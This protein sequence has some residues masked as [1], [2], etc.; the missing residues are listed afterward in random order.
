VLAHQIFDRADL[1][2]LLLAMRCALFHSEGRAASGEQQTDA[3]RKNEPALCDKRV[4]HTLLH[5]P[6]RQHAVIHRNFQ[7]ETQ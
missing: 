2:F 1:L 6:Q 4:C 5:D 3:G 7:G